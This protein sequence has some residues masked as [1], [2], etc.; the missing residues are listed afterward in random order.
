VRG[1]RAADIRFRRLNLAP[2]RVLDRC[3]GRGGVQP[4]RESRRWP[5][6]TFFAALYYLL[7]VYLVVILA[8]IVVETTRQFARSWRPVG[9]AAISLEVVYLSTDPPIKLLRK[10]VPPLRLGGVSLDLSI[11]ILLLVVIGL[12]LAV[13]SYAG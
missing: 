2:L 4:Y 1:D 9:I 5:V 10:F 12:Q 3:G 13:S 8:R 6:T 11:L 7:H